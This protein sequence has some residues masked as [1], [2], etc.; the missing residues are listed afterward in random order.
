MNDLTEAQHAS[1]EFY[2]A[3]RALD[4]QA[5]QERQAAMAAFNDATADARAIRDREVTRAQRIELEA[6]QSFSNATAEQRKALDEALAAVRR[7]R[8]EAVGNLQRPLK[9]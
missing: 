4:M 5:Q 7:R 6:M 3:K 8:N 1:A 2:K 9:A